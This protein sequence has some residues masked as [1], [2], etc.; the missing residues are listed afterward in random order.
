MAPAENLILRTDS[1]KFTH[2]R[3]YPPG[4]G[5]GLFLFRE[6]RRQVADVVFFG[7]Q[8]YLKRYLEG[9]VVTPAQIDEAEELVGRHF[10]R[11]VA[12][13]SQGWEH[14]CQVHGGRLPVVIR[15]VPEGTVCQAITF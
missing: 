13:E 1:Y 6:P 9:P 8:Y 5:A 15:A 4:N 2:W 12:V 14:I 10:G 3:Q 7:L 11:P